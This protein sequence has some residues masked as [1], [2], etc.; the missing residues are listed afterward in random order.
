ML[1]LEEAQ[2]LM[3]DLINNASKN[4]DY[5]VNGSIAYTA[6]SPW[7]RS[8]KIRANIIYN[9]PF[10]PEKYADTVQVCEF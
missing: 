8:K 2:G 7:I 1:E 4:V 5:E 10:D 9:K 6:Q 3:D